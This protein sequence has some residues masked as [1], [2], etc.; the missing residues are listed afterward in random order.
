M[1]RAQHHR[2][3]ARAALPRGRRRE[4]VP[5]L[6]YNYPAFTGVNLAPALIG[7]LAAHPNIVGMKETSTDGAQFADVAA[8]VPDSFT[9]LAGSAPGLYPALCAG[10]RGAI[11]AVACVVPEL[12][13]RA[14]RMRHAQ[15]GRP[16]RS[17]AAAADAARAAVTTGYGIAGPEGGDGRWRD[18][19]AAIR[20]R[21]CAPSPP[22]AS[23]RSGCAA[24]GPGVLTMVPNH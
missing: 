15:A 14:A 17:A 24:V 4:P 10:A 22:T 21:R 3:C 11:L 20:G 13:L 12:C 9:I 5:V 8:V 23:N 16:R 2:R 18:I 6:L 7:T 1:Y 19:P